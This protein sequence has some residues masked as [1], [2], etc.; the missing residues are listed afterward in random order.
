MFFMADYRNKKAFYAGLHVNVSEQSRK[1]GLLERSGFQ[2]YTLWM[3]YFG[4]QKLPSL[5]S[6]SVPHSSQK[7]LNTRMRIKW[8][9]NTIYLNV[10]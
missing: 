4:F 9:N 2:S 7:R 3:G 5:T 10:S 6:L 1:N 8:K